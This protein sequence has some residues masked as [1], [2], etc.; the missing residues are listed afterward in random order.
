METSG[1]GA[2]GL[3]TTTQSWS[4]GPALPAVGF[5]VSRDGHSTPPPFWT[6]TTAGREQPEPELPA[7]PRRT[8]VEPSHGA[9]GTPRSPDG[10]AVTPESPVGLSSGEQGPHPCRGCDGPA[11]GQT[12]IGG[13]ERRLR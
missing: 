9:V 10:C 5:D 3:E 4:R 13:R 7:A 2:K 6:T 11:D 1:D 12:S 8:G